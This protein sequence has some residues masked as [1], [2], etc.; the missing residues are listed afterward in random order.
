M[1]PVSFFA[2]RHRGTVKIMSVCNL[3]R[4]IRSIL[5]GFLLF[6]CILSFFPIHSTSSAPVSPTSEASSSAS[7]SQESEKEKTGELQRE[8]FFSDFDFFEF[9]FRLEVASYRFRSENVPSQTYPKIEN[10]PPES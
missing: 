10:P 1:S 5:G 3:K 7:E 8:D 2:K 9:A 4:R 6:Y